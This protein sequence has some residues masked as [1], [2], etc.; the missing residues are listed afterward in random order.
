M[1]SQICRVDMP[2]VRIFLVKIASSDM[3]YDSNIILSPLLLVRTGTRPRMAEIK[4]QAEEK[5]KAAVASAQIQE[6]YLET[7]QGAHPGTANSCAGVALMLVGRYHNYTRERG[8]YELT[9]R[10]CVWAMKNCGDH[11]KAAREKA[12]K[13]SNDL[14][15]L[16]E[17][18][19]FLEAA[20]LFPKSGSYT[21]EYTN[22][23]I[24]DVCTIRK[25]LEDIANTNG[26]EVAWIGASNGHFFSIY[27]Q[28]TPLGSVR[29]VLFD[30]KDFSKDDSQTALQFSGEN[31]DTFIDAVV[32]HLARGFSADT[33]E[34]IDQGMANQ[35]YVL[36]GTPTNALED[37]RRTVSFS[38]Y[39]FKPYGTLVW[40]FYCPKT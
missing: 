39:K 1:R 5:Y 30:S 27:R 31:F 33:C 28:K 35:P 18:I 12:G 2:I 20:G 22:A 10:D 6:N 13:A 34:E 3:N 32:H 38:K 8:S 36:N 16:D 14:L 19:P 4:E 25:S 15:V 37:D 29:Y 7:C 23:S 17:V 9:D 40:L 24:T 21:E 11:L 26:P